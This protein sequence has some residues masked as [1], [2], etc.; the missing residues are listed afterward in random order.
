MT[1]GIVKEALELLA[2]SGIAAPLM[3]SNVSYR[4]RDALLLYNNLRLALH[5][6]SLRRV[7]TGAAKTLFELVLSWGI[8]GKLLHDIEAVPLRLSEINGQWAL[9]ARAG[10]VTV[11]ALV[12]TRSELEQSTLLILRLT[13][14]LGHTDLVSSSLGVTAALWRAKRHEA[15]A[16]S[17][18]VNEVVR[19]ERPD[20]ATA[21]LLEHARAE[22]RAEREPTDE[23]LR[24]ALALRAR[25]FCVALLAAVPI[26]NFDA[27]GHAAAAVALLASPAFRTAEELLVAGLVLRVLYS[28]GLDGALAGEMVRLTERADGEGGS[29]F[30]S[31]YLALHAAVHLRLA[32]SDDTE[33]ALVDL[34]RHGHKT[35]G[36]VAD[37]A[38]TA[39]T[40]LVRLETTLEALAQTFPRSEQTMTKGRD[41]RASRAAAHD[42][43]F[44]PLPE[45][46]AAAVA[47]QPPAARSAAVAGAGS[48]R[49]LTQGHSPAAAPRER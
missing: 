9:A 28:L 25:L 15:F 13:A 46:Y 22:A 7:P 17:D 27:S 39:Y 18:A 8:D 1:E 37:R 30:R 2:L 42:S 43:V 19:I 4:T 34:R 32:R 49:L 45:H 35:P 38:V 44:D 26:A 6:A 14:L 24:L 21:K 20:R 11:A 3:L 48:L 10:L 31:E 41:A 29:T 40:P 36:L 47:G 23:E 33:P 16:W 12:S 5:F